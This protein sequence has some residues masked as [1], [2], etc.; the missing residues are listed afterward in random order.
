MAQLSDYNLGNSSNVAKST[1]YSD[2]DLR[3]KKHPVLNDITPLKDIDAVKNSVKNLV[4]TNFYERPFHPEI[5][6]NVT[7]LLFEPADV[8]TG[9]QL[10]DEIKR[11]IDDY[12]P[13]VNTVKVE[14]LDDSDANAYII[15]IGFNVIFATE[16]ISLTFNLQRLR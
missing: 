13:R 14:V 8:F 1:L 12:E 16:R 7:R 11:V 4:L 15:S 10:R 6:S 9:I 5:G 2:L 3:F